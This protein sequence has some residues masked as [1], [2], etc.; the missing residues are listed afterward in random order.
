MNYILRW[1]SRAAM[2]VAE[3]GNF[4]LDQKSQIGPHG[5]LW[6]HEVIWRWEDIKMEDEV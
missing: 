1:G 5:G 6:T 4:N 3:L 2:V